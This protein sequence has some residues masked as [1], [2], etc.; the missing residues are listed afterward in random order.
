MPSNEEIARAALQK[1]KIGKGGIGSRVDICKGLQLSLFE[2][3]WDGGQGQGFYDLSVRFAYR[4]KTITIPPSDLVTKSKS[5]W[6][7][8]NVYRLAP[9]T[10]ERYVDQ[11]AALIEKVPA[12][13]A[14]RGQ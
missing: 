2:A 12:E 1:V 8:D 10:V 3:R 14:K 9:A 11:I 5:M 4:D 6:A 7:R 13:L